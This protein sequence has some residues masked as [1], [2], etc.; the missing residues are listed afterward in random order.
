MPAPATR[1]A[2]VRAVGDRLLADLDSVLTGGD[3]AFRLPVGGPVADV[4]TFCWRDVPSVCMLLPGHTYLGAC[5]KLAGDNQM[6]MCD[7]HYTD[8]SKETDE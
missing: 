6:L 3:G 4:G 7:E 2:R 1:T 5:G 8:W